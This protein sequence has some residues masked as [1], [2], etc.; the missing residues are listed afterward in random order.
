MTE[1]EV[2]DYTALCREIARKNVD[3][4]AHVKPPTDEEIAALIAI[5]NANRKELQAVPAAQPTAAGKS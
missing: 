1:P 4:L 5:Q 3:P 2:D